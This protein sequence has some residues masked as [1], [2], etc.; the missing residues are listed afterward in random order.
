MLT[1]PRLAPASA[2]HQ[3]S[4]GGGG[5]DRRSNRTALAPK[6]EFRHA[7][8]MIV[9]KPFAPAPYPFSDDPAVR[10]SWDH[11]ETRLTPPRLT[12]HLESGDDVVIIEGVAEDL[13]TDS[14]LA[15]RIVS[16][17]LDK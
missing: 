8:A 5:P 6:G 13:T 17:W 9:G 15:G 12:V 4:L 11:V 1:G 14:D 2:S 7:G 16:A 3:A 10:W